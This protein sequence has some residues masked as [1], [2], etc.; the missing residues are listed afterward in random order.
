M[1]KRFII[2]VI[3]FS[4]FAV[5]IN[6]LKNVNYLFAIPEHMFYMTLIIVKTRVFYQI[7]NNLKEFHVYEFERIRKSMI[8]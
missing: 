3:S 1:R 2:L 5:I 4:V 6:I 7:Y 8:I